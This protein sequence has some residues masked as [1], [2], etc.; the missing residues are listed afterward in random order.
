M[1]RRLASGGKESWKKGG[2]LAGL[3]AIR[4]LVPF[5]VTPKIWLAVKGA[6]MSIL[7]WGPVHWEAAVRPA[8][9]RDSST[10]LPLLK[11]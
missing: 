3:S 11:L 9:S 1:G 7:G 5:Y 6:G 10:P 2:S 8:L 4:V